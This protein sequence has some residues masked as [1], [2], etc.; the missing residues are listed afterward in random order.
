MLSVPISR[1]TKEPG[2]ATAEAWP[3][4]IQ[5]SPKTLASSHSSTE[6]SVK[7]PGGSIDARST[8][9]RVASTSDPI[10]LQRHG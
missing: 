9:C 5:P 4:Q 3:A 8:G 10:K 6:G 2:S 7:A 1:V